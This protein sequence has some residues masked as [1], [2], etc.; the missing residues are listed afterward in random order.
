MNELDVGRTPPP[1]E[2]PAEGGGTV[3]L[4]ELRG[5]SVVVYFY[6]KDNTTGCT[7]EA[8]DFSA[9]EPEFRKAGV[10]VLGISPD[11]L[12]KHAN[13]RK[14]HELTIELLS[15]E[16]HKVAEAYGLWVEKTF[17]GRKYMGVERT[18]LLIGPDGRIAR[19]WRK[20]AIDGHAREVLDA[21]KELPAS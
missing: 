3:N 20:V 10:R 8:M 12:K 4:G 14:K 7:Q 9:L 15:D 11:S 2:L 18:T 16:D 1:F 6:P 17:Y 5:K 19:V 21:V 13:F